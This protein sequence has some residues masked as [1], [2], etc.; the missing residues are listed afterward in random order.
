MNTTSMPVL[1][2]VTLTVDLDSTTE[3][4][5]ESSQCALLFVGVILLLCHGMIP[6]LVPFSA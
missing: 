6:D 4:L 3:I 5:I 2:H 1:M